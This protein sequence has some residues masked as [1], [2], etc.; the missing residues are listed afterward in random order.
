VRTTARYPSLRDI[1]RTKIREGVTVS[2]LY[3]LGQYETQVLGGPMDGER[4]TYA[5][6]PHAIAGHHAM[7][8]RVS[9]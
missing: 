2:T 5:T 8:D 7:V 4:Q 1:A 9:R 6:L 3:F